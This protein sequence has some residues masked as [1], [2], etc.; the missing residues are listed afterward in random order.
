MVPGDAAV[1][2]EIPREVD[3]YLSHFADKRP[4]QI[5]VDVSPSYLFHHASAA[6]IERELPGVKIVFILRRPSDKIFSQYTSRRRGSRNHVLRRCVAHRGEP[7]GCRIFG[8]VALCRKRL[9]RRCSEG[10]QAALGTARIMI[11]FLTTSDVTLGLYFATYA[12]L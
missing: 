9:L 12:F 3:I 2:A 8:H 1:L 10:L 4:G 5:A 6:A 11:I 7:K